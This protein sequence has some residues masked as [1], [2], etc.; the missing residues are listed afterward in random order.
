MGSGFVVDATGYVVTNQ[1][2]VDHASD[3]TVTLH[4]GRRLPAS[5]VGVDEKTD[6]ALLKVETDQS[7]PY[8]SFG[9]SDRTRIGDW[10]VAIGNPF[11]FGGSATAGI[12][13]ARGRDIQAG[14]FDD[15]LRESV[16]LPLRSPDQRDRRAHEPDP[17]Q[18]RQGFRSPAPPHRARRRLRP[19]RPRVTRDSGPRLGV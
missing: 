15:F 4:D 9:D 10:V 12:V 5:L 18:D 6:L 14:P 13:S 3:I 7:L 11:G 2:V 17:E 16:G 1:H 8:A 19:P